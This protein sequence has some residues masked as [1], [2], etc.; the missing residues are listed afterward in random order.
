MKQFYYGR[1]VF[2]LEGSPLYSQKSGVFG[3][4]D[5]ILSIVLILYLLIYET[6]EK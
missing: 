5:S 2:P 3:F 6:F 4:I 1:F